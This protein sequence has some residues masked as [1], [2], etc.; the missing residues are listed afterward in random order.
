MRLFYWTVTGVVAI[1][2]AV[3]A[4]M[5]R[6]LVEIDFPLLPEPWETRLNLIVLIA[7]VAGF[8]GGYFVAWNYGRRHR[9]AARHHGRRA[10]ALERELQSTRTPTTDRTPALPPRG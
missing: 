9:R 10:A 2:L 6:Q 5:N 4:A 1:L 8:L 7:L 3:F